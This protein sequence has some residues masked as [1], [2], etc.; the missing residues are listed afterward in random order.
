MQSID[1]LNVDVDLQ[2]L[3]DH[4]DPAGD[5]AYAFIARIQVGDLSIHRPRRRI[6]TTGAVRGKGQL[7]VQ[8]RARHL[9]RG[10]FV[11]GHARALGPRAE[12]VEVLLPAD[13]GIAQNHRAGFLHAHAAQPETAVAFEDE[14]AV[15]DLERLVPG[16]AIDELQGSRLSPVARLLIFAF[17]VHRRGRDG[18]GHGPV[19]QV[20]GLL[21]RFERHVLDADVRVDFFTAIRAR[22]TQRESACGLHAPT[23]GIRDDAAH[24]IHVAVL[25]G[26][27]AAGGAPV[28]VPGVHLVAG[29][30]ALDA[31]CVER[32]GQGAIERAAPADRYCGHLRAAEVGH[33]RGEQTIAVLPVMTRDVEGDVDRSAPRVP[34][35]CHIGLR[36]RHPPGLEVERGR[37][38]AILRVRGQREMAV[39][40]ELDEAEPRLRLVWWR[41]RG[42][43]RRCQRRALRR[44]NDGIAAALHGF[45]EL[46][47]PAHRH[48]AAHAPLRLERREAELARE[49]VQIDVLVVRGKARRSVRYTKRKPIFQPHRSAQEIR[50]RVGHDECLRGPA[51]ITVKVRKSPLR[52]TDTEARFFA[53][54]LSGQLA[55]RL[56]VRSLPELERAAKGAVPAHAPGFRR[57]ED[58]P[59]PREIDFG[60]DAVLLLRPVGEVHV[61]VHVRARAVGHEIDVPQ[62]DLRALQLEARAEIRPERRELADLRRAV[63]ELRDTE[64][65][66]QVGGAHERKIQVAADHAPV[67]D[68]IVE[69]ELA[70]VSVN[71]HALHLEARRPSA[72]L[73]LQVRKTGAPDG[74]VLHGHPP[75]EDVDVDVQIPGNPHQRPPRNV[76]GDPFGGKERPVVLRRALDHHI[77]QRELAR[78]EE[79]RDAADVHRPF[80]ELRGLAFGDGP[81]GAAAD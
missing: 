33:D 48:V 8:G 16:R 44:K 36:R 47:A 78:C 13:P 67:T 31:R 35:E 53:F 41:I 10:E 75:V 1:R 56:P 70:A 3:V 59:H 58:L 20:E 45:A 7:T 81:D 23:S 50:L 24:E 73:G 74:P 39:R 15:D 54:E 30:F 63:R 17:E 68:V 46:A 25:D 11:D 80:Q 4:P 37:S 26:D 32:L 69:H 55:A 79:R 5:G 38:E 22:V 71:G 43:R 64:N 57:E 29:E 34:A 49:A 76:D 28:D 6:E 60:T 40:L 19:L 14:R 66:V 51:Q 72:A 18:A 77:V 42:E 12:G 62:Q 2:R 61:P 27:V 65:R 9:E 21:Q 52:V